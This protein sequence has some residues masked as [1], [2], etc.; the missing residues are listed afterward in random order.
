MRLNVALYGAIEDIIGELRSLQTDLTPE[1]TK[2]LLIN[3]CRRVMHLE[4]RVTLLE[5]KQD[6]PDWKERR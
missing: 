6:Q 1:T 5:E 2:A 4:Q 3:I